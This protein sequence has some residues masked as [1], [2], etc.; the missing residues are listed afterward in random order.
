MSA[1]GR[2][3][4]DPEAAFADRAAIITQGVV[5]FPLE[6]EPAATGQAGLLD[7]G[8]AGIIANARSTLLMATGS[9]PVR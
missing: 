9:P 3:R 1:G 4:R 5:D 7:I 8:G 2:T 6:C